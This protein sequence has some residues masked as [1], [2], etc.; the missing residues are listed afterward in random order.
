MQ[1]FGG[2][3]AYIATFGVGRSL[4][5]SFRKLSVTRSSSPSRMPGAGPRHDS[6]LSSRLHRAGAKDG[7]GV[8]LTGQRNRGYDVGI[9]ELFTSFVHLL[10]T[11]QKQTSLRLTRVSS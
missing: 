5:S 4:G 2:I 9:L 10:A 6:V 3:S 7:T 11:L 1:A 8:H